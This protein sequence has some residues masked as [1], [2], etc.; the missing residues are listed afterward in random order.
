MHL[1]FTL[2]PSGKRLYT[3]K[4]VVSGRGHQVRASRPLLARRQVLEV[5]RD[6]ARSDSSCAKKIP[7]GFQC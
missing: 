7:N 2:D 5:S 3:L 4:K 6:F 1:M